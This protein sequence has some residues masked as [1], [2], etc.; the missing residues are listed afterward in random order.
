MKI[1]L[2]YG[3]GETY[4]GYLNLNQFLEKESD[5]IKR[6]DIKD[7]SKFVEDGEAEEIVAI[8]I[9]EY[10]NHNKISEVLTN[11]ARKIKFGGKIVIGFLDAYEIARNFNNGFINLEVYN[12]LIHGSGEK[13]YMVKRTCLNTSLIK[14]MLSKLGFKM[15][16][17]KINN[18]NITV[19]AV[20]Q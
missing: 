5:N 11:W 10:I 14:Q 7:I 13:P 6:C 1:N 17:H 16:K 18:F 12:A 15:M 3:E 19:E 20:R 2:I 9:L 4:N 8:G